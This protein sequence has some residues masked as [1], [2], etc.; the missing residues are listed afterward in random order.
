LDVGAPAKYTGAGRQLRPIAAL[1]H[2]PWLW[3]YFGAVWI[4]AGFL[5]FIAAI[6]HGAMTGGRF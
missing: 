3:E 4:G 2:A 6:V 1:L 5:F